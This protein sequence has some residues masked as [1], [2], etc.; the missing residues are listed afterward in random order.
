VVLYGL[1]GP[2]TV[3]GKTYNGVMPPFR[4]LKDQEVADVL[5]Y[6]L[7]LRPHHLRQVQGQA[8]HRRRGQGGQGQGSLPSGR[9]QVPSPGQVDRSTPSLRG[10]KGAPGPLYPLPGP[11]AGLHQQGVVL[12]ANA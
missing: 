6:V 5:N 7:K 10:P 4:Q 1:Q 3:E 9:A 2:L 8:H 11:H 12:S